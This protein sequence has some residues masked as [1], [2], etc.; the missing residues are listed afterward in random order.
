MGEQIF[1]LCL[2]SGDT[3]VDR[4]SSERGNIES[5]FDL[6]LLVLG[7]ARPEEADN[8]NVIEYPIHQ[9]INEQPV[10]PIKDEAYQALKDQLREYILG[11]KLVIDMETKE[12][13]QI[14]LIDDLRLLRSKNIMSK[15][16]NGDF[17]NLN[18]IRLYQ[19]I[20]QSA[21]KKG[22]PN[23]ITTL[24]DI[25]GGEEV[26]QYL[27]GNATYED[28]IKVKRVPTK[29][30]RPMKQY[31]KPN[32]LIPLWMDF[33]KNNSASAKKKLAEHYMRTIAIP[34][35]HSILWK[36]PWVGEHYRK[37]KELAQL[38]YVALDKKLDTYDISLGIKF[39][40]YA[41][42]RLKGAINDQL[43]NEQ[44]LQRAYEE[45]KSE[46]TSLY[47]GEE[48]EG[49]R[50]IDTIP[51]EETHSDFDMSDFE[52]LM[53]GIP[54]RETKIYIDR[55]AHKKGVKEIA[56]EFAITDCRVSQLFIETDK[57]V[58]KRREQ[59]YAGAI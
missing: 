37:D 32:Y 45:E 28:N 30:D 17:L 8:S 44:I 51:V 15:D 13:E 42:E 18:L 48:D 11:E 29:I 46:T 35:A 40:T 22:T 59:L 47:L 23:W 6:S 25:F 41:S 57:I 53:E 7:D 12:E 49:E 36:T 27:G 21:T 39:N 58:K 24:D 43:R 50:P 33:K 19:R 26:Q 52:R 56:E 38:A 54:P 55:L 10:D 16:D 14:S 20:T 1:G 3:T 34:I 9:L 31:I 2:L 4:E 5:L